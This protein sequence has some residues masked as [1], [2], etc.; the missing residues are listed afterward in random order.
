M[1][2]RAVRTLCTTYWCEN[3]L[4]QR[5]AKNE[6]IVELLDMATVPKW[7]RKGV[8]VRVVGDGWSVVRGSLG[9]VVSL[10]PGG[11]NVELEDGS[12]YSA[13]HEVFAQG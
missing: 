3:T 2:S 10:H 8:W 4:E 12:S 5:L 11:A 6:L 1:A 9:K 7:M 13:P